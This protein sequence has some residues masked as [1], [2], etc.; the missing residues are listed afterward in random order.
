MN[1]TGS[2]AN[3]DFIAAA[4]A[5]GLSDAAIAAAMERP[6]AIVW[7][8]GAPLPGQE[9]RSSGNFETK[10]YASDKPSKMK[11]YI[12]GNPRAPEISF[13]ITKDKSYDTDPVIANNLKDGSTISYKKT[14]RYYIS[15]PNSPDRGSFIVLFLPES[16]PAPPPDYI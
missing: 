12:R 6:I 10:W 4:R 2:H 8:D 1:D 14:S 13:S 3:E 9:H 15:D 11:V 5:A 7:S 16:A